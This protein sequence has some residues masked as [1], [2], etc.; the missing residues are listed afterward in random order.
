[1]LAALAGVHVALPLAYNLGYGFVL[2]GLYAFAGGWLGCVGAAMA[3][4]SMML[5]VGTLRYFAAARVPIR[6][7]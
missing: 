1:M 3:A 7:L 6:T 2:V 5:G 4:P